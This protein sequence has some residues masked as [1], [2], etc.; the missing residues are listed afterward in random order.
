MMDVNLLWLS[1]CNIYK[2]RVK[3]LCCT[4]LNVSSA[5]WQLYLNKTERKKRT[6]PGEDQLRSQTPRRSRSSLNPSL[7]RAPRSRRNRNRSLFRHFLFPGSCPLLQH[8][9][10]LNSSSPPISVQEPLIPGRTRELL[11]MI[12]LE[13]S[14]CLRQAL[15]SC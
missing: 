7:S 11:L 9:S 15:Y 10:L 8:H 3:S 6:V 5:V 13:E 1:F 2:S 14:P 12:T 4:F